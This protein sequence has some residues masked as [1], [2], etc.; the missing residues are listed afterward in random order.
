MKALIG[1]FGRVDESTSDTEERL[2]IQAAA[3]VDIPNP[4]EQPC[5][6]CHVG[7]AH[8]SRARTVPERIKK[9]L[10]SKRL[11]RCSDCGWRGWLGSFLVPR[12]LE[13]SFWGRFSAS[14]NVPQAARKPSPVVPQQFF[15]QNRGRRFFSTTCLVFQM[16]QQV[17]SGSLS[18]PCLV[19]SVLA[20]YRVSLPYPAPSP[21]GAVW[22]SAASFVRV[23]S[24]ARQRGSP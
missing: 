16:P 22:L 14:H 6:R 1:T 12:F 19:R 5:P 23:R 24:F 17:R 18:R 11:F 4:D 10:T 21:L 2:P 8:R 13:P 9:E 3:A 20:L 7:R 15:L